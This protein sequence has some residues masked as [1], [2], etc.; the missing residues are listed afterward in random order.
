MGIL[1]KNYT[2]FNVWCEE[3]GMETTIVANLLLIKKE[4]NESKLLSKLKAI[5]MSHE[6][7]LSLI[8]TEDSRYPTFFLT[9]Y[10]NYQPY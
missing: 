3:V 4:R 6:A 5:Q 1:R 7:L 10:F 9:E 2:E 8:N